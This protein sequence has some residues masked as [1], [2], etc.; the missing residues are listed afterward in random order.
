MGC[1]SSKLKGEK[2]ADV[3]EDAPQP[4]KKVQ[5]NFSTIDYDAEGQG[6][7]DTIVGPLEAVRQKPDAPPPL[8]LA[9]KEHNTPN[10]AVTPEPPAQPATQV[11]QADFENSLPD[12]QPTLR[13]LDARNTDALEHKE[14]YHD[15]TASPITPYNTRAFG[16]KASQPQFALAFTEKQGEKPSY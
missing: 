3:T 7:R 13:D 14:P 1:G 16:D 5:T 15:V 4:I 11:D 8:P 12:Q 6:R 10:A 2:Q 9:E